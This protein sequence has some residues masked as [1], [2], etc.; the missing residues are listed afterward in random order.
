MFYDIYD[1]SLYRNG[2][3]FFFGKQHLLELAIYHDDLEAC[4]P[5]GNKAGKRKV[6][7]FYYSVI[8]IN[9]EFH[10]KHCSIRLFAICNSKFVK[11]YGIEKVL[12][13]IVDD[14]NR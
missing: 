2:A 11:K 13:P 6:D 12:S 8:N 7:T 4:N 10:S 1:R 14:I 9:P 3:Y 5:L